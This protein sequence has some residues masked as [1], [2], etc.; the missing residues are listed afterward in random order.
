MNTRFFPLLYVG[1]AIAYLFLALPMGRLADRIGPTR[2]FIGGQTLLVLVDATLLR[3]DP[4]PIALIIMLGALGTYYAATDGILA[5]VATSILPDRQRASGLALLGAAMAMSAFAAS[6]IFGALW[7]WKG[8]NFAVT[9]FLGG[10]L[11][12]LGATLWLLRPRLLY[13]RISWRSAG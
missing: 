4:G 12:S 8:P 2:V 9:V 11:I 7:Q 13:E 6:T 1:T 3:S 10:I 5:V